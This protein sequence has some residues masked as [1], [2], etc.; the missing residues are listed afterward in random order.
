MGKITDIEQALMRGYVDAALGLPTA[1]DNA[2]FERPALGAPWARVVII[3]GTGARAA[4]CGDAGE[5]EHVGV[6]QIDVNYPLHGGI[7][8]ARAKLDQAAAFF[9]AGR[10]LDSGDAR[11]TVRV[12]YPGPGREVDGYYRRTLT[13]PWSARTP[14]RA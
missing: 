8:D 4:T 2:L 5:D 13:V 12:P 3:H 11:V 6:L 9:Y 14:R 10:A 7:A 1:I